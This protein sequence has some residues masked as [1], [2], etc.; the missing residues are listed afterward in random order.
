MLPP[1]DRLAVTS[2]TLPDYHH[3]LGDDAAAVR[4][5]GLQHYLADWA[6]HFDYVLLLNAADAGPWPDYAAARL[7]PVNRTTM[8]ALFRVRP[9][10]RLA[11]R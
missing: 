4:D 5:Y 3:L 2:G 11:G 6:R 8:A 1:Y 10:G 7:E 9:E